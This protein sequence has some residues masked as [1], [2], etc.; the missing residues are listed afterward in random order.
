MDDQGEIHHLKCV[1]NIFEGAFSDSD[2]DHHVI[3]RYLLDL[4]FNMLW[5]DVQNP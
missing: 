2:I 4:I 1:W 5:H 3:I